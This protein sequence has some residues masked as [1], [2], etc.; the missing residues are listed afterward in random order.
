M[1]RLFYYLFL[2]QAFI[3]GFVLFPSHAFALSYERYSVALSGQPRDV[4]AGD[5]DSDGDQDI[6]TID[7][8][9]AII[10]VLTNEGIK[11]GAP[12]FRVR[13]IRLGFVPERIV[14]SKNRAGVKSRCSAQVAAVIH[15][16][17]KD[18]DFVEVNID[19]DTFPAPANCLPSSGLSMKLQDAIDP[20]LDTLSLQ[21]FY[22]GS[23][24]QRIGS[25]SNF[26]APAK[27]AFSLISSSGTD[28]TR[29]DLVVA[30]WPAI[31]ADAGFKERTLPDLTGPS[32]QTKRCFQ[33]LEHRL[34]G[35][36]VDLAASLTKNVDMTRFD[37]YSKSDQNSCFS[38][39]FSR[40][41][42]VQEESFSNSIEFDYTKKPTNISRTT[43][44]AYQSRFSPPLDNTA[45]LLPLWNTAF[46]G[47]LFGSFNESSD[48]D[49]DIAML[50]KQVFVDGPHA[51]VLVVANPVS[52]R[53]GNPRFVRWRF[54]DLGVTDLGG[55]KTAQLGGSR[56]RDRFSDL[57]VIDRSHQSIDV[58][59][60]DSSQTPENLNGRQPTFF[61]RETVSFANEPETID[62][63]D[64]N[65]DHVDDFVVVERGVSGVTLLLNTDP[66]RALA[67]QPEP[68]KQGETPLL[69]VPVSPQPQQPSL[70]VVPKLLGKTLPQARSLVG[71]AHCKLGKTRVPKRSSSAKRRLK[72]RGYRLLVKRQTPK[73]GTKFTA[74]KKLYLTFAWK[75]TKRR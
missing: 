61:E 40:I 38:S 15:G 6:V 63:A 16:G 46:D 37:S 12:S 75:K 43:M 20:G 11:S 9:A 69:P 65:G 41:S 39:D 68:P 72:K 74:G 31:L 34:T 58:L 23:V 57:A 2:F 25:S 13:D 53:Y 22:D 45:D 29:Q 30:D 17:G 28:T 64:F 33:P 70:C 24:Y 1:A 56:G 27:G 48:E 55:L 60:Q 52:A 50:T 19:S 44:T 47:P 49:S 36:R 5:I 62:A 54:V 42:T 35:V 66:R 7:A 73:A 71:R 8:D 3:I 21:W 10:S 67:K 14:L 4:A 18:V 51:G 32:R 26:L 59:L